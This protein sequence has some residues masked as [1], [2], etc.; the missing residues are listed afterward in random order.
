MKKSA[1]SASSDSTASSESS[2]GSSSGV[3]NTGA[4]FTTDELRQQYLCRTGRESS[5][6]GT[7]DS[8]SG[9]SSPRTKAPPDTK[10]EVTPTMGGSRFQSRFLT[11]GKTNTV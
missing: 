7:V 2:T 5:G 9:N 8:N 4:A 6:K 10:K 3:R 11:G 1:R